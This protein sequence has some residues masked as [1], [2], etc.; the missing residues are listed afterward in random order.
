MR[1]SYEKSGMTGK[2]VEQELF[3]KSLYERETKELFPDYSYADKLRC[4]DIIKK[5]QPSSPTN[6]QREFAHHVRSRVCILLG[7]D[8]KIVRFYTAVDSPLD[9][10]HQVDG[11]FEIKFRGVN[12]LVTV[13]LTSRPEKDKTRSDIIF[14]VPIEGLSSAVD[15]TEFLSYAN[16]MSEQ[17]VLE[18]QRQGIPSRKGSHHG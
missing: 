6:P 2:I 14:H 1:R 10:F 12:I 9:Q 5:H 7:V 18:F 3:G 4:L 15:E 16:D 11:W 8:Q 13:D 17:V